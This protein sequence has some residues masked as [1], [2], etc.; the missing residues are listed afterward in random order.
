MT[1]KVFSQNLKK[2]RLRGEKSQEDFANKLG[3][4]QQQLSH[5]E[6]GIRRPSIDFLVF[7]SKETN[8]SINDLLEKNLNLDIT[9]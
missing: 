7:L 6:R 8:I 4:T 3:L 9:G 1:L 5:L 2:I